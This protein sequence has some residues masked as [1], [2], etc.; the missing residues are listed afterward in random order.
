M[1]VRCICHNIICAQGKQSMHSRQNFISIFTE[2]HGHADQRKWRQIRIS[3]VSVGLRWNSWVRFSLSFFISI[4][5]ILILISILITT[6]KATTCTS[7]LQGNKAATKRGYHGE[8][9]SEEMPACRSTDTCSARKEAWGL[10]MFCSMA[11]LCIRH[12]GITGMSGNISRKFLCRK[13]E[14]KWYVRTYQDATLTVD[15]IATLTR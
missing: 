4:L 14:A 3:A 8:L 7:R 2:L 11:T 6:T 1:L 9:S 5:T 10:W 13:K 12:V 15:V